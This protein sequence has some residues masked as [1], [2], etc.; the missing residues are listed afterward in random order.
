MSPVRS[1]RSRTVK[2]GAKRRCIGITDRLFGCNRREVCDCRPI[3]EICRRFYQIF[4]S[5]LAVERHQK[6]IVQKNRRDPSGWNDPM[7]EKE[8]LFS[9]CPLNRVNLPPQN[10][11]PLRKKK[12][13]P[14]QFFPPPPG[15]KTGPTPPPFFVRSPSCIGNPA[16]I[17]E[18][19]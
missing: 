9:Y 11:L 5:D 19:S 7:L 13:C 15:I 16:V 4:H 2:P 17:R 1:V 14:P 6:R 3:V 10:H 18:T 12:N 8:N